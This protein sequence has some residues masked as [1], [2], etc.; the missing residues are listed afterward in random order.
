[1]IPIPASAD[2]LTST[3]LSEAL[4]H[5]VRVEGAPRRLSSFACEV[6]RVRLSGPPG[7]PPGVVIKLPTHGTARQLADG[8]GIYRRE[9]VFYDRV[10]EACPLRTPRPLVSRMADEGTDFVLVLEDLAPLTAGDQL[11]GLTLEQAER[12]I[13]QLARFHAWSWGS[14]LL[15]ELADTFPALDSPRGRAIGEQ[16]AQ[17]FPVGWKVA[18][19]LA[20]DLITPRI[21]AFADHMASHA[22]SLIEELAGPRV[23]VHGELRA[24]NLVLD[25]AGDPYFIDFQNAQLAC[26][27]R[28][29]AY[30][31]FTSLR[32]EDRQGRD[33]RLVRRYWDGLVAAGVEGYPWERAWRQYRLG[34]ADQLIVTGSACGQYEFADDRGRRVLA[35]MLRRALRAIDDNAALDLLEG[36]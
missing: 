15:D 10:A 35:T 8:L 12:V 28:E 30:L 4:G 27:P 22:E 32:S 34:L 17:A 1:V 18:P 16:W 24:D 11:T 20:G 31:L 14:P 3:W 26:G 33:E 21:A 13:D 9:T 19:E 5:E 25:G 29:L 7:V 6:Y 36:P 2:E 23:L